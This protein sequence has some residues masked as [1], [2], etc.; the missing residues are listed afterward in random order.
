M[1][2][3]LPEPFHKTLSMPPTVAL[4]Q[5]SC[6][7]SKAANVAKALS[8]IA[9]AA[10]QWANIVC[11]Q[12]LFPGQYPCQSEDY[13]RFAEAEPIPGP[14][15]E[16]LAEAARRHEVVVIGSLFE[17]RTAGVYHNTAVVFDADGA[18]LGL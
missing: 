18:T 11:L 13:G 4:V 1:F 10:G 17:R 15:S 9:D 16:A 12:E 6:S 5:M 8:R 2:A 14:T 7:A 3:F